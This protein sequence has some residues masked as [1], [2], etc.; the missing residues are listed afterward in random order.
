LTQLLFRILGGGGRV[1][2]LLLK[3][4]PHVS[5][6]V[7]RVAEG[8][9]RH[10]PQQLQ[11]R[12]VAQ[13]P[14]HVGLALEAVARRPRALRVLDA[15]P[16]VADGRARARA[17]VDEAQQALVHGRPVVA[18][19][20]RRCRERSCRCAA[21]R[22]RREQ[23]CWGAPRRRRREQSCWCAAAY[24]ARGEQHGVAQL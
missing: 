6:P 1:V 13:V 9:A 23:S 12:E 4:S 5:V 17:V 8:L 11:R 20:R 19:A 10:G 3:L 18:A 16:E 15:G 14:L 22:R 24:G 7:E 21:R 2:L